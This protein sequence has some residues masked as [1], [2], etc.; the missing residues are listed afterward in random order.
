MW[1]F[2]RSVDTS[3]LSC[4]DGTNTQE[5][6]QG[7]PGG[8]GAAGPGDRQAIAQ[9]A[10]D[11]DV[12]EGTLDNWVNADKRRRCEGDGALSED[13]RSELAAAR[14]RRSCPG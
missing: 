14:K 4:G 3:S 12:N 10:R 9:V 7:L 5:V 8:R 13:E 2:P 11:L 1:A 6:R